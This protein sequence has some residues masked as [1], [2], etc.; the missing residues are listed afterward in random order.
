MIENYCSSIISFYV[1]RN[2][3][4]RV[5][6]KFWSTWSLQDSHKSR[7]Y[8]LRYKKS[9]KFS[10]VYSQATKVC[11][12]FYFIITKLLIS[13]YICWRNFVSQYQLLSQIFLIK[14]WNFTKKEFWKPTTRLIQIRTLLIEHPSIDRE[15]SSRLIKTW[16]RIIE[17]FNQH[18]NLVFFGMRF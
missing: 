6:S 17:T 9:P 1:I 8:A 16:S 13:W 18:A 15:L 4:E 3:G 12:I 10:T 5:I 14:N 7:S 11:F 2:F